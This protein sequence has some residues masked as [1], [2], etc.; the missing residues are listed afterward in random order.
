M[1]GMKYVNEGESV[2]TDIPT[3]FCRM[4]VE[5][6]PSATGKSAIPVMAK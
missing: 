3:V 5:A 6:G 2:L 4:C 1:E